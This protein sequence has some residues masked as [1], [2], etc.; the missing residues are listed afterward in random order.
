MAAS[1]VYVLAFVVFLQGALLL[2]WPTMNA[3]QYCGAGISCCQPVIRPNGKIRGH[4]LAKEAMQL[5]CVQCPRVLC[6]QQCLDLHMQGH[7]PTQQ[8]G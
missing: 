6:S 4:Y 7:P 8:V 3:P 5:R 2:P 1:F